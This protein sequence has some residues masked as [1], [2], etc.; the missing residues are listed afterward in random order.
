MMASLVKGSFEQEYNKRINSL[1]ADTGTKTW[2]DF[3]ICA[4]P[5]FRYVQ[6]FK[7]RKII[8][9]L[10]LLF[11]SCTSL[12]HQENKSLLDEVVG[13]WDTVGEKFCNGS[14]YTHKIEL[15]EN[16]T[17]VRFTFYIE[18]EKFIQDISN[19]YIYT[20]LEVLDDR[21]IM[22]VDGETRK[23]DSGELVIWEFIFEKDGE[24]S[25]RRTDW[26]SEYRVQ[27]FQKRC[28]LNA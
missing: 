15:I 19:T 21:I 6:G 11:N 3:A 8:L 12:T 25:W 24:Y 18:G 26:P 27:P 5:F 4:P 2:C 28:N 20:V 13:T 1:P 14:G 23:T 9:T 17:K 7:M 16:K 22:Q 10:T